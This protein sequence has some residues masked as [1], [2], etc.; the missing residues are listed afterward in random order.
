MWLRSVSGLCM[1][2]CTSN[3]WACSWWVSWW[4]P[5]RP[6]P[7]LGSGHQWWCVVALGA[8]MSHWCSIGF[9]SAECEAEHFIPS[10][11]CLARPSLTLDD[12]TCSMTFNRAS[13]D[14]FLPVT[15]THEPALICDRTGGPANCGVLGQI[16]IK[17]FCAGLWA[18]VVQEDIWFIVVQ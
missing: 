1:P 17:L 10:N 14:H 4:C 6:P 5:I 2:H 15:C 3:V 18:Q 9:R 11:K 8:L 16:T 7:R 13:L 12:V